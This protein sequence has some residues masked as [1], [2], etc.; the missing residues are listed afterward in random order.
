MLDLKRI[1]DFITE[2][3][4]A[5]GLTQQQVAEQLGVSYQAVSKW[6]CG[7]TLPS[8]D[9]LLELSELLGVT[10]DEL[11]RG[12]CR[13]DAGLTYS[14]AGVDISYTDA[15]KAE[16]SRYVSSDHPRVL[17]RL[18]AFASLYD[19]RFDDIPDPVL[20]L[21]SEEPGSKQKIAME[22]GYTES[23]C[24]DMINH[25]VNDIIVMGA[26]P[27]AVLDTIVCGSAEKDTVKCF[28]KGISE[29]CAAN[30]CSLV[31]G[32]TSVQPGVVERGTYILTASIA[33]ICS[34]EQL[35]DGSRITAGDVVLSVA[36]NGLHT[37][38]Y[39]LVRMLMDELPRIK[40]ERVG[41]LPFLNAIMLP[42]TPYY[43][44][45][46]ELLSDP[47][48]HGMAH[49][50]GGGIAGNL[51]RVIPDGLCAVVDLSALQPPAIFSYLKANGGISDD[52]MLRTFNCGAGL[53]LV[54]DRDSAPQI[55]AQ[56]SKLY[57]CQPIGE[58]IADTG[59]R[60]AF[61]NAVRW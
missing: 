11:L 31:G 52:E 26:K 34:R 21:K 22:Y 24:H 46:R 38:G 29:A 17:N 12:H 58:I 30:D 13:K 39:S 35:I 9:S 45:L 15:I 25:L 56:I 20:V 19:I 61:Q 2:R 8:V 28:I 27:L 54:T 53:I 1:S 18:G 60:V 5:M 42:H 47:T 7:T 51:S 44:A 32:E 36:S 50:T 55:A 43:P 57:P 4:R 3:R 40:E 37:N 14:K 16:M 49:I 10:A 23:I 41:S 48:L 59:S 6:E 33:G